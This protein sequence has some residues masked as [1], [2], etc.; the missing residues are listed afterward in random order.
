MEPRLLLRAA[1]LLCVLHNAFG[2][3]CFPE[4][5]FVTFKAD[6]VNMVCSRDICDQSILSFPHV[7]TLVY[8][9]IDVVNMSSDSESEMLV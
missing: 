7:K 1:A 4:M 8:L 3:V 2:E 6:L 9:H 5:K